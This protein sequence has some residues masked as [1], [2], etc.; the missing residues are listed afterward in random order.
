MVAGRAGISTSR[1]ARDHRVT[2]GRQRFAHQAKGLKL[3]SEADENSVG[4]A[5]L[6]LVDPDGNPIL[7]DQHV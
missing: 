6:M 1:R 5:S 7:I 2:S 3:T 4:P